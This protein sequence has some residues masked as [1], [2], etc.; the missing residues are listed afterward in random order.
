LSSPRIWLT[1]FARS[2]SAL[3]Q[4]APPP[5]HRGTML[6]PPELTQAP[7]AANLSYYR[8]KNSL[9]HAAFATEACSVEQ[10]ERGTTHQ[11]RYIDLSRLE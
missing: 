10:A 8:R 2:C 4:R 9:P 1:T 3:S 5:I 7:S 6:L 11:C